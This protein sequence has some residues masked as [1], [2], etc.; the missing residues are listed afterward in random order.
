MMKYKGYSGSVEYSSE[1]GCLCGKVQGLRKTTITYEGSSIDE[2][3]KDFEE[4]IDCYLESCAERNVSP[5]KP[6]SGKLLLRMP[7]E[8]H[9]EV[10]DAAA[11]SG[12]TI[13][14]FINKVLRQGMGL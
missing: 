12:C 13:N 8:L 4:S 14:E 6:Y 1:D 10:A 7:S 5:E 2:I 11:T 3:R 9:G